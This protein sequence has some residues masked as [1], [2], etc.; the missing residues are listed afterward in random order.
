LGELTV[1]LPVRAIAVRAPIHPAHVS[2]VAL[3]FV[4]GVACIARFAIDEDGGEFQQI[5]AVLLIAAFAATAAVSVPVAGL[6]VVVLPS[7]FGQTPWNSP[8]RAYLGSEAMPVY[9]CDAIL[10]AGAAWAA[11][12][13]LRARNAS[14]SAGRFLREHWL[15]FAVLAGG[16]VLKV[17]QSGV[18]GET[19]R[20]AALF[21]YP[22]AVL[23][24]VAALAER[25][26]VVRIV[27]A[28]LLESSALTLL[29]P[30]LVLAAF[31]LG[32]GDELL[33]PLRQG[34][35]EPVGWLKWLPPGSLILLTFLSAAYL[36]GPGPRLLR[37]G[38]AALL[39][40]DAVTYGN[41]AMWMGIVAGYAAG[42]SVRLGW[43]RS[44]LIALPIALAL[45]VAAPSLVDR[46]GEGHNESGE[47]RLLAWGL[48]VAGIADAPVLGHPYSDSVL[49]QL[50]ADPDS[51]EALGGSDIRINSQARSPHNS[52]LTLL[53]FGG[54]VQGGA[55]IVLILGTLTALWH[56]VALAR[57][58]GRPD[59][60]GEALLRGGVAIAVYA[61]FNVVLES[62][63]EGIT[64]WLVIA[65]AWLRSREPTPEG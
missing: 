15:L 50:L 4:A 16:V 57:R 2:R 13:A 56:R 21:Y 12:G 3:A 32:V 59:D 11:V 34:I 30:L 43:K 58:R 53:F 55:V 18:S 25:L 40:Y 49:G 10:L 62:P 28:L 5:A 37:L 8:V 20:N 41:R 38:V 1:R 26:D 27:P 63:I 54:A 65:L 23:L 47:W 44:A 64:F 7:L 24:F 46:L 39:A 52:Y 14:R 35:V 61:A 60:T 6:L 33:A 9:I 29:A 19:V 17:A 31:M 42:I 22:P 48:T 45:G 51:Q 36:F